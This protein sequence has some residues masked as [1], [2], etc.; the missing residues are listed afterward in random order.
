MAVV[1]VGVGSENAAKIRAVRLAIDQIQQTG[2]EI[3]RGCVVELR[4]FK[5][6]TRRAGGRARNTDAGA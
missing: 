5:V 2:A 3:F 6:K 1:V 4:G